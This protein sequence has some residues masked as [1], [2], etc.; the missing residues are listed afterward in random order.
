MKHFTLLIILLFLGNPILAQNEQTFKDI[1]FLTKDEIKI[2]GIMQYPSTAGE[3]K[4]PVVIL[5]HQG[6]SSTKEWAESSILNKLLEN[7]FAIL[8]YDIR[9]HGESEKDGEFGDLYNNPERAPLDLLAAIAY[10]EQDK[11]IDTSRI[12][13]LGA[14]IGANLACMAAASE[15]YNIKSA[16]SISA[17][18]QAA[19][20]LSGSKETISP[21]NVFYIASKEEQDGK[22]MAW[23]N[24]LYTLTSGMK[25]VE[26]AEGNKHGSF[27]LGEHSYLES[28]I[29]AWFNMSLKE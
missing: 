24:E 29:I 3:S 2:S 19:Q 15:K 25:K 8:A 13:I 9:L 1:Q 7:G 27:I 5:I 21:K 26:I 23:A 22:R 11:K 28:E 20:N 14:S 12:G 10:L 17:K 16:V 4:F 18:T 6:G